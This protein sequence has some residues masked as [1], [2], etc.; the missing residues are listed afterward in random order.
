MKKRQ[1][2]S[3][4]ACSLM[5]FTLSSPICANATTNNNLESDDFITSNQENSTDLK[6]E[7][8]SKDD[9]ELD[10][11]IV[12]YI[13]EQKEDGLSFPE[14]QKELKSAGLEVSQESVNKNKSVY[15]SNVEHEIYTAKRSGDSYYRIIANFTFH[16]DPY[17]TGS[18]D[19]MSIEWDSSKADYYDTKP[20]SFTTTMDGSNRKKGVVL[21]NVEDKKMW[22]YDTAIASVYVKPKQ[23]NT[24]ID[25]G[26]KY[27]HT[28]NNLQLT[29]S[30]GG[31]VNYQSTGPTGGGTF[32][33]T[34][35]S[36]SNSWQIY[37]DNDFSV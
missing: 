3:L 37:N 28:F 25:V 24:T 30:I 4:I 15:P 20:S 17:S 12:D 34:G 22:A 21:F 35:T 33:V 19:L 32:N 6:N 10:K 14:I 2:K 13:K 8:F 1:L 26:S 9:S 7:I 31:N 23:S 36:S 27:V 16:Q 18:L 11:F 29:W 5:I